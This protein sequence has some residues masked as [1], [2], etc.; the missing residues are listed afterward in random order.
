MTRKMTPLE[1]LI[2]VVASLPDRDQRTAQAGAD[3]VVA[4]L[5]A[6]GM[7]RQRPASLA[8]VKRVVRDEAGQITAIVEGMEQVER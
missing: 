2:R 6:A 4:H 3:A 5:A 8:M 7:L 1:A